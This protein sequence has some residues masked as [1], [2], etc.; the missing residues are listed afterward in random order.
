D[1]GCEGLV[2]CGTTG[3]AVTL[4]DAEYRMVV[5]AVVEEAQGRVPVVAGAGTASTAHSI[6]LAKIAKEVGADGLLL[7]CPYYNRPTQAGLE[8]NFRAIVQAVPLPS[9]L[10]NIPVRCGVDMSVETLERLSDVK[11]II[12]IKEATNNVLRSQSIVARCGER[13]SVMSGDDALTVPIMA[14][15]GRGVISV[16]ANAFPR[17]V[18]EVARQMMK[19]EHAAALALHQRLL[20]VHEVMFVESNPGPLKA[21]LG[22][23]GHMSGDVRLPLVKASEDTLARVRSA[24]KQAGLTL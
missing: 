7:V 11:E 18:S 23:A 8:A 22:A 14:V 1:G 6:H 10:Y 17:E 13:F 9:I 5:R 16:S 4:S 12:G 20:P 3:E 24:V 21:L 15:G 19:G 2:P